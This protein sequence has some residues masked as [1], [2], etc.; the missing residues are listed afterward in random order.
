ME[1]MEVFRSV[2]APDL[3]ISSDS[4]MEFKISNVFIKGC[5]GRTH[6][7]ITRSVPSISSTRIFRHKLYYSC[8]CSKPPLRF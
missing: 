1:G 4:L 3:R 5:Y 8:S 7:H 2:K 6:V